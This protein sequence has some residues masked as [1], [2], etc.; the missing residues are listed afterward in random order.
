MLLLVARSARADD[1]ILSSSASS[2][3]FISDLTFEVCNLLFGFTQNPFVTLVLCHAAHTTSSQFWLPA[4]ADTSCRFPVDQLIKHPR[5]PQCRP[6]FMLVI[7]HIFLAD[8]QD[9]ASVCGQI[10]VGAG[11]KVQSVVPDR[12][13]RSRIF[14]CPMLMRAMRVFL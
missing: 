8:V 1:S 11:R 10:V 2:L 7:R 12:W 5:R 14:C 13:K 3:R 9:L 4:S 6:G